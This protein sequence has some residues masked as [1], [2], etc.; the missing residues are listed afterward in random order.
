MPTEDE[1]KKLIDTGA[2]PLCG[3]KTSESLRWIVIEHTV[4]PVDPPTGKAFG[5]RFQASDGELDEFEVALV[6]RECWREPRGFYFAVE[7]GQGEKLDDRA[8]AVLQRLPEIMKGPEKFFWDF[9]D[10]E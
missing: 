5:D 6:C 8:D 1:L 3:A 10:G 7:Q 2:C 9:V 4:Y